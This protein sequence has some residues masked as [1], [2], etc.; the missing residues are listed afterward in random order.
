MGIDLV[1]FPAGQQQVG[2]GAPQ[3]IYLLQIGVGEIAFLQVFGHLPL[4]KVQRTAMQAF[5]GIRTA[6][7]DACQKI[8]RQCQR[9]EQRSEYQPEKFGV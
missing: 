6:V 8:Q 5:P 9:K 2:Q 3:L 4:E 1:P 7:V